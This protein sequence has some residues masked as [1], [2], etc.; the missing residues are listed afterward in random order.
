M[1]HYIFRPA[2]QGGRVGKQ[3]GGG[4]K[5][6]DGPCIYTY[7]YIY[8]YI[9][10]HIIINNNKIGIIIIIMSAGLRDGVASIA[11][12]FAIG[13]VPPLMPS[14]PSAVCR[15]NIIYIYIYIYRE[16]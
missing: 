13:A 2:G 15:A 14:P 10:I 5:T 16:R 9:Y 8:I 6:G 7:L 11:D 3:K 4:G 1:L 12:V